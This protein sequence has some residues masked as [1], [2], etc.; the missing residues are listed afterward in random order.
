M[1]HKEKTMG[2]MNL[3]KANW[4]G[5][6]GQVVGAKWKNKSTIRSFTKPAY[7]NTPAQQII[8]QGF[9]EITSF[10]ALF[11]DQLKTYSALNTKGMSLRNAIIKLNKDMLAT[12]ALNPASLLIARGGLPNVSGFTPAKKTS[13]AGFTASWT[14]STGVS[15]SEKARVVAIFVDDNL[16]FAAVGAALNS[17]G[18]LDLTVA[19][20]TGS[21]CDVYYYLLD[22][23]GS[24]RVS[25]VSNY[26]GKL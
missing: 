15:I 24:S 8:R 25:S 22:Y 19:V 1:A 16:N 23:R 17:A 9:G 2:I 13:N 10:V 3:L 18:T 4:T 21:S 26:H 5:K 11:A 7:T 6:V 14:P 20:P 12:G